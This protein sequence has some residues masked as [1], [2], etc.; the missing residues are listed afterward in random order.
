VDGAWRYE[1]KGAWADSLGGIGV[2][3]EGVAAFQDVESFH[4]IVDMRRVVEPG[5]LPC[6]AESPMTTGLGSGCLARDV[7]V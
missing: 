6:L 5:L 4:F 3:V 7:C 1:D 2:G